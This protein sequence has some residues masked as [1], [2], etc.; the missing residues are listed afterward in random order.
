[1]RAPSASLPAASPEPA[2][3]EPAAPV[4]PSVP[5][6]R[7]N[8]LIEQPYKLGE[9]AVP[10]E[11]AAYQADILERRRW[12]DGS[13]GALIADPPLEEGHPDPRVIVDV[14]SSKGPHAAADIQRLFRRN[15]WIEVIECYR[16]AA[17]KDRNLRGKTTIRIWVGAKGKITKSSLGDTTFKERDV[18]E[19]LVQKA[20]SI[21]LTKARA[22]STATIAVQVGPGDE[23]LAPP[24][25]LIEPGP[26][27]L[28]PDA[29]RS[30]LEAAL[31]RFHACYDK[32]LGYAPE[33]W[34]RIAVRFHVDRSGRVDEAFQTESRFPEPR[35]LRCVL[36][37]ARSLQFPAP[38]GGDLR[39]VVPLRFST[40]RAPAHPVPP[41]PASNR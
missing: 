28:S 24:Q 40:D 41:T 18:P 15:F 5:A 12:N 13:V 3:S 16:L 29:I 26:G 17:Y 32:A 14:T 36:A 37:E 7:S 31:P 2:P 11:R 35:V 27:T 10:R 39:F 30:V 34:G 6:P 33:L 21:E 23:P 9:R 19:C 38:Q 8:I 1:L 25:K 4:Q 22:V 20:R